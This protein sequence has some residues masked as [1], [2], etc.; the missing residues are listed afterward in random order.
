MK[1]AQNCIREMMEA[2]GQKVRYEPHLPGDISEDMFEGLLFL[3]SRLQQIIE[4]HPQS[5]TSSKERILRIHLLMEEFAEY[6]HAEAVDDIVKIADGLGDMIVIIVGTALSYG[7]PIDR[8]FE[9]IHK[10]NMSK[11]G[12]DGKPIKNDKGKVMKGPDYFRPDIQGVL[13]IE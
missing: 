1:H 10:S 13:G 6:L 8:V 12:P 9:E 5:D 3:S 7:I 11:L 2:F 4:S